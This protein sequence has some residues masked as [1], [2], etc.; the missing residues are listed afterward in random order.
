MVTSNPLTLKRTT[1]SSDKTEA[2]KNKIIEKPI[3]APKVET[4]QNELKDAHPNK[5]ILELK[6]LKQKTPEKLLEMAAQYGLEDGG[7]LC[8]QD[9]IYHILK[10]FSDKKRDNI[11]IGEGV[12]EVLQ[13]GFGFLRAP[14]ANYRPG[15]DDIYV[16]PSQI[17]RFGLRTGDTV[18]G[19]IRISDSVVE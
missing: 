9:V 14:Q 18:K 8:K 7:D 1:N 11:I 3:E 16:S 19:Q 5:D 6:T 12:L 2:E 13:D 4:P 17:K 15:S 10:S